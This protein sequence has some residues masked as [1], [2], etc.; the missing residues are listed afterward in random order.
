MGLGRGV[1]SGSR[2]IR[3]RVAIRC[4]CRVEIQVPGAEDP[5]PA[6]RIAAVYSVKGC[7]RGCWAMR[8]MYVRGEGDSQEMV[9]VVESEAIHAKSMATP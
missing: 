8:A 9:G 6:P 7:D 4:F 3:F 1:K 5:V 2:G